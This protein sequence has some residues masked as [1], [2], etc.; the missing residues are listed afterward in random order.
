M[1]RLVLLAA[2]VASPAAATTSCPAHFLNGT[3]PVITN[4]KLTAKARELCYGRYA[5]AHSGVL[6]VPIWSAEHMTSTGAKA[7]LRTSGGKYSFKAERRLPESERAELSDYNRS[8][9]D[10]GHMT[11]SGNFAS[12]R[13]D[14]AT[15]TLANVVPQHPCLNQRTWRL[16]EEQIL[17]RAA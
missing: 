6:R 15:F 17:K 14:Q 11:P 12:K 3:A 2:L 9:F 5:V 16:M 1:P 7:A 8:A 13:D 10:R 4:V